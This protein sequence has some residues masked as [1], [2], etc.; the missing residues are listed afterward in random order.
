MK[1]HI[2]H[3]LQF[4]F[5]LFICA[6]PISTSL[7]EVAKIF[8]LIFFVYALI[9]KE[10]RNDF[11]ENLFAK[12]KSIFFFILLVFLFLHILGVSFTSQWNKSESCDGTF[13]HLYS[14]FIPQIIVFF[15]TYCFLKLS[16]LKKMIPT[17]LVLIAISSAYS[18]VMTISSKS[19]SSVGFYGHHVTYG[20]IFSIFWSILLLTTFFCLRDTWHSKNIKKKSWDCLAFN[21]NCLFFRSISS[22][23]QIDTHYDPFLIFLFILLFYTIQKKE[24]YLFA[25]ICTIDAHTLLYYSQQNKSKDL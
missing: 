6:A 24:N 3:S 1:N 12:K 22:G 13:N 11:I 19:Y 21:F 9:V 14:V 16:T 5:I 2:S 4:P 20:K 10:S 18:F 7:V 8:F 25:V 23:I 15:Y 17:L